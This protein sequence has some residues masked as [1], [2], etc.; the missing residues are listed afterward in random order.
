MP[1]IACLGWGSLVWD[2][3]ALPIQRQ[4][5]ADGPFVRA[6]FLRKSIDDRITLVLDES[7]A[8]VRALWAVMDATNVTEAVVALR[9]R[10]GILKNNV[11]KHVGCWKPGNTSHLEILNLAVWAEARGIDAV[12]WTALPPRFYQDDQNQVAPVEDIVKHLAGLT[13]R[14]RDEAERYV[15]YAPAQIDTPYRREIERVLG[16]T[17]KTPPP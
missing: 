12:V 7:A 6:E 10:E 3:R 13:G 1:I 2:P 16:W 5:F 15:R 4:W 9:K 11:E 8:P 17:P 14:K